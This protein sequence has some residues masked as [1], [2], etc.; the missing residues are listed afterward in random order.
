MKTIRTV[1]SRK[2]VDKPVGLGALAA[3]F[4][5]AP[6]VSASQLCK[7]LSKRSFHASITTPSPESLG[8][9]IDLT[10]DG[11]GNYQ[12]EVRMHHSG[13]PNYSFRLGIFLR[14]GNGMVFALYSHGTVH[15]TLSLGSRDFSELQSGSNP[16]IKDHWADFAIGQLE[17][18]KEYTNDLLEW[19]ESTFLDKSLFVIGCVTIG[20]PAACVIYGSSLL[21][22]LTGI[23]LPGDIGSAGLLAAEGG[24][25]LLGPYSFIPVFIGGAAV[26]AA[27]FKRRRLHDWEYEAA[28]SLFRHSLPY[29]RIWITNLEGREG[30]AF[31]MPGM[32]GDFIVGVGPS[33]YENLIADQNTRIT[34]FHELTHVWQCKH[35][36]T[37]SILCNG[38][39]GRAFE[40]AEG[41][42]ALYEV[43]SFTLPWN[44]YNWEQKANIV[45][46]LDFVRQTWNSLKP[47]MIKVGLIKEGDS[48]ESLPAW[49]LIREHILM[50]ID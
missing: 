14:A 28:F 36:S 16:T 15:G 3:T 46:T 19:V 1:L 18:H 40:A 42:S 47:D 11:D 9:D 4:G 31:A 21:G 50:G 10:I 45:A 6:P 25:F 48:Y 13:L 27:L 43:S 29:E 39:Y 5:L 24:F 30:R 38:A 37:V 35:N 26:S 32:D 49:R 7:L 2:K 20:A 23:R 33:R 22:K 34:F 12:L 41:K 8:G 17:V 44:S